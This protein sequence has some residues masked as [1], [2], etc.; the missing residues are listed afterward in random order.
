MVRVLDEEYEVHTAVMDKLPCSRCC[1]REGSTTV[2]PTVETQLRQQQ[3][4]E[5]E[6]Q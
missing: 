6:A 5:E 2:G 1:P 3:V 4:A